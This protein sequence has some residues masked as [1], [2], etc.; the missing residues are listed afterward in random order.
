MKIVV[1]VRCYNEQ[2]NIKR[3]LKG[4]DWA[5]SIVVSDGGSK[6]RSIEMLQ[7]H[8]KVKLFHFDQFETVERYRWNPDAPHMNFVLEKAKEEEPDW[9]I[10]DDMDD[11]PNIL[12]RESARQL[13][14]N[15]ASP[16]VNAFRLYLWGEKLFFPKMNNYFREGWASLWAW[17]PKEVDIHADLN[18]RH[19]TLTGLHPTP[20]NIQPPLCLLHKSWHPKT[21]EKKMKRYNAL[22]L[23]MNHPETFAG[24]PEMLPDWAHT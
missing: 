1:A 19:G 2:K 5:D 8:P 15:F 7:G 23:T 20:Y 18:V 9:I 4:Y 14:E 21:I 6:D 11:V 10:F 12:L 16:Q 3:F 24:T 13:L 17:K 22:G